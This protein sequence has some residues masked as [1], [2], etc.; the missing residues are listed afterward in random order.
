MTGPLSGW[1]TILGP[2]RN[3]PKLRPSFLIE[4]SPYS[5]VSRCPHPLTPIDL[6]SSLASNI[7]TTLTL[8]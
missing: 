2:Y 3:L 8:H 7:L 4:N 5:I 6:R 1:W